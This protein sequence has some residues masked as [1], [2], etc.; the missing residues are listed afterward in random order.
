MYLSVKMNNNGDQIITSF[1]IFMFYIV[2][3]SEFNIKTFLY[4]N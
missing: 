3:E 2:K 1:V 4:L